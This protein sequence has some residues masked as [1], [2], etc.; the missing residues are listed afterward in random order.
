MNVFVLCTGRCG[1]KTFV[2]ACRHIRNFSVAHES[3]AYNEAFWKTGELSYPD[4]HIEVDNRLSWLMPMLAA[5]Y[6]DAAYYV[7]LIRNEE[8]TAR[9]L[10]RRR[11]TRNFL[12]LVYSTKQKLHLDS[13]DAGRIYYHTVNGNIS[14]FLANKPHTVIH[15]EEP[16]KAF[17]EFWHAIGATGN[18]TRAHAD[19]N[20]RYRD[21]AKRA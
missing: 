16:H 13:L 15:I 1:S 14:A 12:R 19:L 10:R 9:S 5:Q 3:A 4:N 6:G 11:V 8:D 7:H 17:D 2:H 21:R 18:A 20:K